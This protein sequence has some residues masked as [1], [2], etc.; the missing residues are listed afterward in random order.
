[1][2]RLCSDYVAA[3]RSGFAEVGRQMRN[4]YGRWDNGHP[5]RVRSRKDVLRWGPAVVAVEQIRTIANSDMLGAELAES[6]P[7]D[8]VLLPDCGERGANGA[9]STR[10]QPQRQQMQPLSSEDAVCISALPAVPAAA[11][12]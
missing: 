10:R 7:L 1:M 5:R 11:A 12:C 8:R 4:R 2:N 3:R 6:A 9:S